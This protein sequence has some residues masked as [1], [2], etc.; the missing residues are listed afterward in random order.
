MADAPENTSHPKGTLA[1]ILLYLLMVAVLWIE[2]Y[3]R[4]W[5]P[6]GEGP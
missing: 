4:L 1:L 2:T 6:G 3:L 5:I